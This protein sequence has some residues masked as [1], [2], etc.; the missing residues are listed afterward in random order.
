MCSCSSESKWYPGLH[1]E[2]GG[3]QGQGGDCPSLL[4]SCEAPSGV[5]CPGMEPPVQER[6]RAVGEGPEEGHK[7]DQGAGAPPLRG[8]A[9]GAGLIQPG[10]EKA[11]G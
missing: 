4:C 6:Q 3:Q 8:Q 10:E 9:E 7:D 11:A 5:L 2:R 1:H